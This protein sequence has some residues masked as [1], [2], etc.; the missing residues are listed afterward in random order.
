MRLKGHESFS[1]RSRHAE[2]QSTPHFVGLMGRRK[3]ISPFRSL[4]LDS[5]PQD[6]VA[7]GRSTPP[8]SAGSRH[9]ENPF[10]C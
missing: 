2:S 8:S 6:I 7:F 10:P 4:I 3:P 5:G 9:A 1:A